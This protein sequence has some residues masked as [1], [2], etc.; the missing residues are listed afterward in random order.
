MSKKTPNLRSSHQ[1]LSDLR[2][3]L[4]SPAHFISTSA[5]H[6]GEPMSAGRRKRAMSYKPRIDLL[7]HEETKEEDD[8]DS[9]GQ[10]SNIEPTNTPAKACSLRLSSHVKSSPAL[11][12]STS[13][14]PQKR[15][16]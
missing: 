9:S 12:I 10:L 7:P 8:E 16:S 13:V 2:S 6:L 11:P 5:P 1:L 14:D 3:S 15:L 4:N